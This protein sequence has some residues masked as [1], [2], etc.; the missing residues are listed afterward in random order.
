[1]GALG[2][3]AI[4]LVLAAGPA[5]GMAAPALALDVPNPDVT[6]PGLPGAPAAPVPGPTSPVPIPGPPVPGV[7]PIPGVPVLPGL[8]VPLPAL[9]LPPLVPGAPQ[10]APKPV[11][12][13]P[14]GQGSI[15]ALPFGHYVGDGLGIA[16]PP[17]PVI[18]EPNYPLPAE[19]PYDDSGDNTYKGQPL[20]VSG[21]LRR[22]AGDRSS[23]DR[24]AIAA[25]GH[26][27]TSHVLLDIAGL[28][29]VAAAGTG[30]VAARKRGLI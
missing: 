14:Q 12:P 20:D 7:P 4:V 29:T 16:V 18:P 24:N 23:V 13:P 1:M 5:A 25:A 26:A 30:I 27:V 15:G 21:N 8:P 19:Q 22:V 9:P 10:P 17:R 2:K 3:A 11:G 6:L 28:L